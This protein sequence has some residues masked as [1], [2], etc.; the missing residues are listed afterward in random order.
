MVSLGIATGFER[1][2]GV[3]RRLGMTPLG[4]RALIAAKI[5]AIIKIEI[6]QIVIL[7]AIAFAL[8]WHPRSGIAISLAALLL[9][10]VAF[11]GIGLLLAGTLRA[12]AT[13]AF[14]NGLYVIFL[15]IGGVIFP[16]NKLGGFASFARLLP[17]AALTNILHSAFAGSG[18]PMSAW[19]ILGCWA[20]VSPIVA[21]ALFRFE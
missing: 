5:L 20:L 3:L 14:A 21:S 16:L 7:G 9:A 17:T 12:E 11:G 6:I 13:L 1:S 4:R 8:G 19:V 2:Y 15:L 18:A 10:S